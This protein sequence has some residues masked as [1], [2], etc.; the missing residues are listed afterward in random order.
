M[1][2]DHY[3]IESSDQSACID[4]NCSGACQF[5]VHAISESW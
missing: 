3:N 1:A 2:E 4:P 5:L